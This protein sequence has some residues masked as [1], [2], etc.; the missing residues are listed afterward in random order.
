MASLLYCRRRDG[1]RGKYREREDKKKCTECI[2]LLLLLLVL[3]FLGF[4]A[5][6]FWI[7]SCS[8]LCDAVNGEWYRETAV[9]YRHDKVENVDYYAIWCGAFVYVRFD[10][11]QYD[12]GGGDDGNT[13][14]TITHS[15]FPLCVEYIKRYAFI[16]VL[17]VWLRMKSE[18]LVQ[19][20]GE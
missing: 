7:V 10:A 8:L 18:I 2:V 1:K 16:I 14:V 12:G 5:L 3:L 19:L 9:G 4:S 11:V 15:T 17:S 20:P 6:L 13:T